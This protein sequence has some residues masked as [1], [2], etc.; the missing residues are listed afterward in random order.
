MCID[1][2]EKCFGI[3]RTYLE[4]EWLCDPTLLF[5]EQ[6]ADAF[7]GLFCCQLERAQFWCRSLA[8][9]LPSNVLALSGFSVT[10]ILLAS[11]YSLLSCLA[12][13]N[14][15]IKTVAKLLTTLTLSGLVEVKEVGMCVPFPEIPSGSYLGICRVM[16]FLAPLVCCKCV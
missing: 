15:K 10:C 5:N 1:W 9:I 6:A 8:H 7:S 3:Y 13:N 12:G 14:G 2:I 11:S 4:L 16:R